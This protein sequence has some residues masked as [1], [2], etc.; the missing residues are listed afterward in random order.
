V[1]EEEGQDENQKERRLRDGSSFSFSFFQLS[2]GC[3]L[4]VGSERA[5]HRSQNE[6]QN[7]GV[8]ERNALV[9]FCVSDHIDIVLMLLEKGARN[10]QLKDAF[11]DQTIDPSQTKAINI[12]TFS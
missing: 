9:K 7:G 3:C 2:C 5:P 12:T 6:D 10:T 4:V 1:D 8:K 11:G